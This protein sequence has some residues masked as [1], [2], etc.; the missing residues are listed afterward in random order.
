MS[1][2]VG[3]RKGSMELSS[4]TAARPA[5]SLPGVDSRRDAPPPLLRLHNVATVDDLFRNYP[6]S[7]AR[8]VLSSTRLQVAEKREELRQVTAEHYRDFITCTDNVKMMHFGIS[9]LME[10]TARIATESRES[11][12][13]CDAARYSAPLDSYD[14]KPVDVSPELE[15]GRELKKLLDMSEAVWRMMED[16]D[17]AGAARCYLVDLPHLRSRIES[18]RDQ[19]PDTKLPVEQLLKQQDKA[20][21]DVPSTIVLTCKQ[22]LRSLDLT[23]AEVQECCAVLMLMQADGAVISE[24]DVDRLRSEFLGAREN[25]ILSSSQSVIDRLCALES[26]LDVAS[27][28]LCDLESIVS[29]ARQ[30]GLPVEAGN[31]G[32]CGKF[33]IDQVEQDKWKKAV[34]DGVVREAKK[35]SGL[36]DLAVLRNRLHDRLEGY[37]KTFTGSADEPEISAWS[38]VESCLQQ[39]GM[40]LLKRGLPKSGKI[41]DL[42]EATVENLESSACDSQLWEDP[43]SVVIGAVG[44]WVSERCEAFLAAPSA[45]SGAEDARDLAIYS[46]AV[47]GYREDS[48][49]CAQKDISNIF[50]SVSS[51]SVFCHDDSAL[52]SFACRSEEGVGRLIVA[53]VSSDKEL[54]SVMERVCEKSTREWCDKDLLARVEVDTPYQTA[55]RISSVLMTAG[56]NST[57]RV[58]SIIRACATRKCPDN[59]DLLRLLDGGLRES[60]SG[61]LFAP[62]RS[63]LEESTTAVNGV[64]SVTTVDSEP[65]FA[66]LSVP[67]FSTLPVASGRAWLH[68]RVA[69][70]KVASEPAVAKTG[71]GKATASMPY[72][73]ASFFSQMGTN[74][75][76][77][78]RRRAAEEEEGEVEEKAGELII[79]EKAHRSGIATGSTAGTKS[80]ENGKWQG[81]QIKAGSKVSTQSDATRTLETESDKVGDARA[82][83][84][85]NAKI[86][87]KIVDGELAEGLYRGLNAGR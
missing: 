3:E 37:I 21:Q 17:F 80:S 44:E 59:A 78:K 38:S 85:R 39:A 70:P 2:M 8:S 22:A 25:L 79:P 18:L 40:L 48:S 46:S 68:S 12:A 62:L 53:A 13:A 54:T 16:K 31:F 24:G 71:E 15:L 49:L 84:E 33:V 73:F 47:L 63:E 87:E 35:C 69:T 52:T 83:Y 27:S 14:D 10:N 19:C 1:T 36:N 11:A 29:C 45:D 32:A 75:S 60:K 61:L 55:W 74:L 23:A 4:R 42:A 57:S 82:Q 67:R 86:Q 65:A 64:S 51:G 50:S 7:T 34:L 81:F 26:T 41:V 43:R 72:D 9:H 28:G 66:Q 56:S 58:L 6:L 30:K 76:H 5:R 77:L 20:G